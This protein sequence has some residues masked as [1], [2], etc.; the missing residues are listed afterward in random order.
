MYSIEITET[1]LA[2]LKKLKGKYA[3]DEILL[4]LIAEENIELPLV[5]EFKKQQ[6]INLIQL[7]FDVCDVS[8]DAEE[9][10]FASVWMDK[11]YVPDSTFR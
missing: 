1:I 6:Y 11:I 9:K 10:A 7:L 5:K 3:I 4:D 8:C 2:F